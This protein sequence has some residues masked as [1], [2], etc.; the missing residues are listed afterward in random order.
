MGISTAS[1]ITD[2]RVHL[3]NLDIGELDDDAALLLLNRSYW[4]VLD[5]FPFR[6]KEVTATFTT[7]IG[8]RNY[9]VPSPFEALRQLSIKDPETNELIVLDRETI[10]THEET[11]DTDTEEYGMPQRYVREGRAIRLNPTPDKE[12]EF[13]IKY[14]TVLS[15][16][17]TSPTVVNLDIPQSWHEI[18]LFGAVW[19]GFLQLR[20]FTA[21]QQYK[22]QQT[23]LINSAVPVE[24]KEEFDSHKAH[25]EVLGR[26]YP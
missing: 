7:T 3:G 17:D 5:K 4:E 12:Y 2:L 15:D 18:I 9:T 6:E 25:L 14:W 8:K 22:I 23:A 19:R 24:A 11:R 10:Y 21:S 20:D 1:L 16:L 26:D 13:T